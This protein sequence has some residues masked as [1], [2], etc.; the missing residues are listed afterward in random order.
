MRWKFTV[1]SS[2]LGFAALLLGFA[3]FLGEQSL[4]SRS[5]SGTPLL[6]LVVALALI[7]LAVLSPTAGQL[8][9]HYKGIALFAFNTAIVLLG[10]NLILGIIFG[11]V[12]HFRV[13]ANAVVFANRDQAYP[14]LAG[15]EV[16]AMLEETYSRPEVFEPFTQFKEPPGQGAY[17]N[18]SD[19]GFRTNGDKPPLPWPPN[20]AHINIF[21]FGGSTTFGYGLPDNETVPA[22]LAQSLNRSVP[23]GVAVYNFG[24]AWYFSTQERILFEQ[25]LLS[26]HVPDVAIF[27]DGINDFHHPWGIPHA[28]DVLNKAY[29]G[30][31]TGDAFTNWPM[32]RLAR[33]L[34]R[35]LRGTVSAPYY[36]QYFAEYEN[37][38]ILNA[39]VTR[40][41]RNKELIESAADAHQIATV[42]V[43]QPSPTYKYDD[44]H[45]HL[46]KGE[47]YGAHTR[48]RFGYPVMAARQKEMRRG[49]DFLWLADIQQDRKEPLYC[50]LMHYTS[51]FAKDIA[52]SV[53]AYLKERRLVTKQVIGSA[54]N[55]DH[56]GG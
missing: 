4:A 30:G 46:F 51:A 34:Q 15:S 13:S 28:S 18:V 44:D 22:H 37:Q 25:L 54:D 5:L 19:G 52:G 11:I 27:I 56:T 24:R 43:W 33:G 12:D 6:S 36:P 38:D 48:S 47:G 41:L 42:F 50:D 29:Q 10:I 14:D 49:K 7:I 53:A 17:V 16:T 23:P 55:R 26:G 35:R 9:D 2:L 32:A 20:A 1:R 21:V 39:V 3:L 31:S 8:R 40:Y 45:Y